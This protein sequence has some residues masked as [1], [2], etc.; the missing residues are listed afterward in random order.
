MRDDAQPYGRV[1]F[2]LIRFADYLEKDP[3]GLRIWLG[4]Q[5]LALD[6]DR[7][8]PKTELIT[9][10][11]GVYAIISTPNTVHRTVV[12]LLLGVCFG[13]GKF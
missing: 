3:I 12:L 8:G 13:I 9:A 5:G 10:T 7:I 11:D 1:I 4:L 6:L 2:Q